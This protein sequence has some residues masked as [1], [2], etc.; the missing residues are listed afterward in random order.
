M[1]ATSLAMRQRV[2]HRHP[3]DLADS[4]L[5]H[6]ASVQYSTVQFSIIQYL[7]LE[8]MALS[9]LDLTLLL[10]YSCCCVSVCQEVC[11]VGHLPL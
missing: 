2:I 5:H 3:S 1:G 4:V 10:H 6:V 11:L 7:W 8:A 9:Q